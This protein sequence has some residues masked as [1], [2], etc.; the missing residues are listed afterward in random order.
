M[1][2]IEPATRLGLFP[3]LYH[4]TTQQLE[5]PCTQDVFSC[6]PESAQWERLSSGIYLACLTHLATLRLVE[7]IE[8]LRISH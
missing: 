5:T 7:G 6:S 2:G 3:T 8:T 1:A 4:W